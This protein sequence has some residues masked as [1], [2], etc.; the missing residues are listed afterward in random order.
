MSSNRTIVE[1]TSL[2]AS[3]AP[4]DLKRKDFVAILNEVV[5][6]PSFLWCES[7]VGNPERLIR[8]QSC[9]ENGGMPL[10]IKAICLPFVFVRSS[11]GELMTLDI[12]Q[13]Q[14][15]RLSKRYAKAVWGA[16][17]KRRS[18]RTKKS[19]GGS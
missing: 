16:H 3:V 17:R 13:V 7:L 4:E 5:E 11:Q 14:L 2:A 19:G 12:R 1:P 18:K 6:Y 8:L 15:V 9:A 10:K